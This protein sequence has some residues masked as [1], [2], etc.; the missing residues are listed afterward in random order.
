MANLTWFADAGLGIFIHWDHASQRGIEI[1][2]PLVGRSNFE[3]EA[4]SVAEYHASASTFDPQQWDAEGVA[5]LARS[6]GAQYV[7]F[8]AR[9][10]S[11]YSMFH[12]RESN[13]SIEHSPYSADI[14][15]QVVEACRRESLR[16][17][18]YYS[19]P[20][21][22]HP[23]Y[24]AFAD[25]DRPYPF[26][27]YRRPSG[28]AWARY[29]QY[30][31][32]QLAE[33]LSEYGTIDLLWFDLPWERTAEEWQAADLRKFIKS[34]QPD[35]II[36]D[37]LPGEGDYEI[38]EQHFPHP[39]PFGAWELCMTMNDSWAWR[40]RDT[41]YKSARQLAR[42]LS[43]TVSR[44]GNLLLNIS[45]MGDGRLPDIQITRL[46]ELG[47]WL[48]TH[49]EAVIGARPASPNIDFYGPATMR[50]TCMY[51]FLVAQPIETV[52]VHGLP[53]RRINKISLLGTEE[54]L[55]YHMPLMSSEDL[56]PRP[57]MLG[58][59]II[60]APEATGALIDVIAIEFDEPLN[61]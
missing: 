53:M 58:E 52:V 31:R 13:F 14:T 6:C 51:L 11:G 20:D 60:D 40:P 7:V 15:R 48:N 39:A 3:W 34:L 54:Q 50:G 19:L 4:V 10:H 16:I 35:I 23:D 24:P 8:T 30:V 29:L 17:G 28:E 18:L 43:E 44:G 45:P 9:H 41:N 55:G 61:A 36:N 33:L 21:W 47:A 37:R 22:H 25:S 42:Y 57:D 5:R 1:S 12:T 49:G 27:R 46:H 56:L 32:G 2:W 38:A 59:L 26:E